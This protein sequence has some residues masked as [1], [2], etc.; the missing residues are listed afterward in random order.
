MKTVPAT[1]VTAPNNKNLKPAN[2]EIAAHVTLAT[3]PPNNPNKKKPL[4][5]N[6]E[7][8]V[9]V[10]LATVPS[11]KKPNLVNATPVLVTLVTALN[12]LLK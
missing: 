3:V 12:N 5:A 11:N 1:L 8:T 6:V 4:Y 10:T 2:V 9:N 7:T